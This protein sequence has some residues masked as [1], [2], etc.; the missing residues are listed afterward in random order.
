MSTDLQ[1]GDTKL[2]KR[3][4]ETRLAASTTDDEVIMEDCEDVD[5][6]ED[7][8]M[9]LRSGSEDKGMMA[10]QNHQGHWAEVCTSPNGVTF[11]SRSKAKGIVNWH[12]NV[13]TTTAT[14]AESI[15]EHS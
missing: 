13:S 10:V 7:K 6:S 3:Q 8:C 4:A 1:P 9:M 12:S 14:Q 5:G 2:K 11:K 15:V